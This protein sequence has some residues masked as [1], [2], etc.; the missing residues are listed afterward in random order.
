[1]D[2][3]PRFFHCDVEQCEKNYLGEVGEV[4]ESSFERTL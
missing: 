4:T 3:D 1:M 2:Y